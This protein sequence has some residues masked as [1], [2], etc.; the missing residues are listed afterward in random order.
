MAGL[1]RASTMTSHVGLSLVVNH[2]LKTVTRM[3]ILDFKP[4]QTAHIHSELD[5]EVIPF[6]TTWKK[7]IED[8][9]KAS[10][11]QGRT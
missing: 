6:G 5:A 7:F 4:V 10:N 8:S 11:A 3:I 2:L 9:S 1:L